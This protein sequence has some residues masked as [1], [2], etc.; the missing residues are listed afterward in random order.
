MASWNRVRAVLLGL[1]SLSAIAKMSDAQVDELVA[2]F[3]RHQAAAR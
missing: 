1:A 2:A 3:E